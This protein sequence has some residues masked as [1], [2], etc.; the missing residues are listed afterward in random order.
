[1][2]KNFASNLLSQGSI[3]QD[4]LSKNV[5]NS[6]LGVFNKNFNFSTESAKKSTI[7]DFLFLIALYSPKN[8]NKHPSETRNYHH[9]SHV[10]ITKVFHCLGPILTTDLNYWLTNCP[11]KPLKH[12]LIGS[13]SRRHRPIKEGCVQS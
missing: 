6:V 2:N 8:D 7:Y 12:K 11:I 1:M 5:K 3:E 10:I 4:Y 9:G 13:F